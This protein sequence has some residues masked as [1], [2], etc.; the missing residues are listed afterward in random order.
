M[1]CK[2][3]RATAKRMSIRRSTTVNSTAVPSTESA[4]MKAA[5]CSSALTECVACARSIT[6]ASVQGV[7]STLA[8]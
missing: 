5:T 6:T 2:A 7:P 4:V 8:A 3:S 1:S